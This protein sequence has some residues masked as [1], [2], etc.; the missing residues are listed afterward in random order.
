MLRF[1]Y[2]DEAL[3][4]PAPPTLRPTDTVRWR[5]LIPVSIIGPGSRMHHFIRC[6]AD[7][8]PD[9]SL[10]PMDTAL[11]L[12]LNLRPLTGHGVRW[13]GQRF[14]L[15][16]ADVD[17]ELVD[18]DGAG[19]RWPAV[20]GFTRASVKYPLLGIA[21]FLEFLNVRFLG[22]ARSIE[23]EPADNFPGRVW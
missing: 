7:P 23:L 17:I 16:F 22:E 13:R 10:L 14:P 11:L 21:G 9:D 19:L 20:V 5:P 15:R 4:G 2:L 3:Q 6:L 8:G 1:P 12:G 18:E